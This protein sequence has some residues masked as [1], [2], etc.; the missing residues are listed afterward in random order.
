MGYG[1][2]RPVGDGVFIFCCAH[3]LFSLWG[4]VCSRGEQ[5]FDEGW[6]RADTDDVVV[7]ICVGPVAFTAE[8]D[9]CWAFDPAAVITVVVPNLPCSTGS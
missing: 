7:L 8:V 4:W 2:D 6:V 1:E 5:A 9:L 3:R